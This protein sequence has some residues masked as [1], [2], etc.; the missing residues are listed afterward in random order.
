MICDGGTHQPQPFAIS[1][2]MPRLFQQILQRAMA[3][4]P[5]MVAGK[6][7]AATPAASP[8]DLH[9]IQIAELSIGS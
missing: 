9:E 1:Q 7:E 5:E 2:P 6:T 8:G 4:G 3:H